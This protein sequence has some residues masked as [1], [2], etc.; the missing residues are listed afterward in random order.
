MVSAARPLFPR[1]RK[2]IRDLGMSRKCH[3]RLWAIAARQPLIQITSS[4][5]TSRPGG[6]S[7]PSALAVCRRYGKLR[8]SFA[9]DALDSCRAGSSHQEKA[10]RPP[11]LM[12]RTHSATAITAMRTAPGTRSR[13]NPSRFGTRLADEEVDTGR[14]ATGR[15]RLA[16]RPSLTGS[17]VTPKTIGIVA[18]AAL[19]ANAAGVLPGAAI[20][21]TRRRTSSAISLRYWAAPRPRGR[22]RRGRSSQQCR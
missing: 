14:V 6:T 3:K 1:K 16:T 19:T 2:S 20:T 12:V 4:V 13:S 7:R 21:A 18:V 9:E 8:D 15:A 5:A 10:M 22:S 11:G 17:S